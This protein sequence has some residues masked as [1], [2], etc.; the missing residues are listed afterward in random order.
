VSDTP[1]QAAPDQGTPEQSTPG[2]GMPLASR[3]G[4]V[5]R[6]DPRRVLAKLFVPGQEML[7]EGEPRAAAVIRRVLAMRPAEIA[8]T[9]AATLAAFADRHRD[10]AL[11]LEAHFADAAGRL[12]DPD[13]LTAQQR[14]LIGAY[15]TQEF[16]IEAAAL[17]N[18]SMVADPDQDGLAPDEVRVVISARAVGEGHLSTVAFR[19]G[20]LGPGR[21][22]RIDDPGDVLVPG[23]LRATGGLPDGDHEIEFPATSRIAERVIWP[24]SPAESHGMEDARFTR[25]VEDDGTATY[26]ATYTAFDGAHVA[27]YLMR[28][29]D[30]RRFRMSRLTGPGARNKGMALFPRRIGGGYVALSRWDREN[31]AITTSTD[32]RNWDEPT[33]LQTPLQPWELT[34]LGNC[35]SP[36]ETPRGWLVLTHGVGPLRVYSIG[37]ILLDLY[38]PRRVIGRLTEPLLTPLPAERIGYVPNVVYSCGGLIHA[39]TLVLPYGCSDSSIRVAQIDMAE[40]LDQ[41]SS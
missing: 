39:D 20:V 15:F 6:A 26:Y 30:F 28:T 24:T 14:L 10:L 16:A 12:V 31:N 38:D 41:L 25:F 19:T 8:A 18:P 4:L 9:L 37:A 7:I 36:I 35:G 2:Q 34:Q 5:L 27:P 32:G 13:S 29:F 1:G 33:T 11:T 17:F 23:V 21:Q 3:T 40:L 22:V